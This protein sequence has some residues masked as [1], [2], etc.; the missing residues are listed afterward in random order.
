MGLD[1]DPV[2]KST[3]RVFF[4]PVKRNLIQKGDFM[5]KKVKRRVKFF[6]LRPTNLRSSFEKFLQSFIN[7]PSL[8]VLEAQI[9]ENM[10]NTLKIKD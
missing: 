7:Y 10:Q 6:Y 2:L 8:K 4:S 5:V 1:D 9:G 3:Y